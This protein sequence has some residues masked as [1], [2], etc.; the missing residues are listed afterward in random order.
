M[1][2]PTAKALKLKSA[3]RQRRSNS[4]IEPGPAGMKTVR[5]PLDSQSAYY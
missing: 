4:M 5:R 3:V 2:S 1:I